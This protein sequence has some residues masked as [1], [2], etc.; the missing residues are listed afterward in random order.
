MNR[1][2]GSSYFFFI[3]LEDK[4]RRDFLEIRKD[5]LLSRL[6]DE[7]ADELLELCWSA[8]GEFGLGSWMILGD[9][10]LLLLGEVEIGPA[11]NENGIMFFKMIRGKTSW[12]AIQLFFYKLIIYLLVVDSSI[13]FINTLPTYTFINLCCKCI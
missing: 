11:R 6:N 7:F 10:A 8:L 12:M 2:N 3:P 4:L 9:N 13:F 1:V 5:W